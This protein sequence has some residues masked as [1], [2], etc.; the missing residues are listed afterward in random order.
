[1][2][3]NVGKQIVVAGVLITGGTDEPEVILYGA[4]EKGHV[5]LVLL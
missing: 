5:V 4:K 2:Q 1:L 3:K